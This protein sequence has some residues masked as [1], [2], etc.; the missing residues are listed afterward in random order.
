[1]QFKKIS[2]Q[3]IM[4]NG[5]VGLQFPTWLEAAATILLLTN[6]TVIK[7]AFVSFPQSMGSTKFIN[8]N[9]S[10]ESSQFVQLLTK[11]V[12]N[13]KTNTTNTDSLNNNSENKK[14]IDHVLKVQI[15]ETEDNVTEG[16]E[17]VEIDTNVLI[18]HQR[19]NPSAVRVRWYF[20]ARFTR[21]HNIT[22]SLVLYTSDASL[23]DHKWKKIIVI[24]PRHHLTIGDLDANKKYYVKVFPR[25]SE[26]TILLNILPLIVLPYSFNSVHSAHFN[27]STEAVFETDR[28]TVVQEHFCLKICNLT[29]VSNQCLADEKCVL[30]SNDQYSLPQWGRFNTKIFKKLFEKQMKAKVEP[31]VIPESFKAMNIKIEDPNDPNF[32]L[33]SKETN[34]QPM[35]ETLIPGTRCFLFDGSESLAEGIS[36]ALHITN[37]VGRK[38]LPSSTMKL[39]NLESTTS[40][41]ERIRKAAMQANIWDSTLVSLPKRRD[42]VLWWITWPRYH[43][44]PV[45]KKSA[46]LLDNFFRCALTLA[47]NYP[48][49]KD[50]RYTRDA[51]MKAFIVKGGESLLC[52]KQQPMM[53]VTGPRPLEPVLSKEAVL[54]TREEPLVSI[55]PVGELIDFTEE[56]IFE[57]ENIWPGVAPSS[58]PS[59]HTILT[60]K[61][62]DYRYPW[63]SK[64]M[65]GNAI[66]SC[67]TAALISAIRQY[68]DYCGVLE[69]PIVSQCIQ[70]CENKFDFIT[71]QLNTTDL[72]KSDGVKNVVWYDGDNELYKTLPYWEQF[73]EVEETNANVLRKFLAMLFN[74]V[75]NNVDR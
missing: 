19:L 3:D 4:L 65:T 39:L 44:I 67:F 68:G 71:F 64:E 12:Q 26:T 70:C 1:L 34:E 23:E 63:T 30:L 53:I 16:I 27:Q 20:S 69:R 75:A 43:G 7:A 35:S 10:K 59:I 21:K 61:D 74:S 18:W 37:A 15:N 33:K 11:A 54:N 14:I 32:G 38:G 22:G 50:L 57:I 47:D 58:F 48:E 17:P 62:K 51:L 6:A 45:L 24:E 55:H 66:L 31:F 60:V 49:V 52:F 42:P 28:K 13:W 46:V 29:A 36:Q 40:L 2:I 9:T 25:T 41:E 5:V 72:A 8:N 73:V 56:N